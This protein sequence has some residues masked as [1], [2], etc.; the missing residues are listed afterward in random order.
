MFTEYQVTKIKELKEAYDD[1]T[2]LKDFKN[3]EV[4]YI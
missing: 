1:L 4:T 2:K 3:R